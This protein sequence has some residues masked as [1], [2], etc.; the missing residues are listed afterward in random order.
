MIFALFL[1]MINIPIPVNFTTVAVEIIQDNPEHIVEHRVTVRGWYRI[2]VLVPYHEFRGSI[3]IYGHPE[4]SF[5]AIRIRLVRF[6]GN[7][8]FRDAVIADFGE[9][10]QGREHVNRAM[11]FTEN[12]SFMRRSVLMVFEEGGGNTIY[13]PLVV[14]G[15]DSHE[16]ALSTV[17]RMLKHSY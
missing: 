14:F 5:E 15:A 2:N 17:R 13:S 16:E 3:E 8:N 6:M 10:P 1:L 4:I 9:A 12:W 11:I 7:R